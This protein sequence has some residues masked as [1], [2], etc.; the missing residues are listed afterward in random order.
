MCKP[1][2][3]VHLKMNLPIHFVEGCQ[4]HI[5]PIRVPNSPHKS[6][7]QPNNLHQNQDMFT[8]FLFYI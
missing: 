8:Y 4:D 2:L 6:Y 1:N 5:Y 7:N 3:N